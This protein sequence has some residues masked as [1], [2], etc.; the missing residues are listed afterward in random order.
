VIKP[1]FVIFSPSRCGSTTLYRAFN[2]IPGIWM[3]YEPPF[4]D[5]ER[6]VDAVRSHLKDMLSDYCGFK[7]VFDLTGC[8]FRNIDF[9]P[10]EEMEKHLPS[11]IELNSAILNYPGLHVIFL[12]RR[13]G[14]HRIVSDQVAKTTNVW[15]QSGLDGGSSGYK[16]AIS[17]VVP[18]PIDEELVRWYVETLP[19]VEQTLRDTVTVNPVLDVW[20]EDLFDAETG[21][22]ERIQ[23]FEKLVEFLEI[24]APG[25]VL[26]SAEFSA[27]FR[28]SGKLNDSNILARIPNYQALR[29]KLSVAEDA[30]PP[31]SPAPERVKAASLQDPA[32]RCASDWRGVEIEY[33]VDRPQNWRLR[34]AGDSLA[35]LLF[36]LEQSDT[37]RIAISRAGTG[38][39]YDIQLNLPDFELEADHSY[40]LQFRARADQPRRVGAGVAQTHRPWSGL[41]FYE[42][43]EL[44]PEWSAFTRE[45]KATASE[46]LTRVHFDL[47]EQAISVEISLLSLLR[48]IDGLIALETPAS[49]ARTS[50]AG[51]AAR[52]DVSSG[53]LD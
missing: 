33:A 21:L 14:F 22:E 48:K 27:L 34:A 6:S 20:Y 15:R 30:A 44:T 2:F 13:D 38:L 53:R 51:S 24:P 8:P 7:H 47:G 19:K 50:R 46:Q 43:I 35:G 37:V 36:P 31:A 4:H 32:P 3:K 9:A 25:S 12:R 10:I 45:F 39:S 16:E 29:R 17:Q 28:L 49:A 1:A 23:R 41:G 40:I 5:I 11:W 26:G 52:C 42:E 18:P